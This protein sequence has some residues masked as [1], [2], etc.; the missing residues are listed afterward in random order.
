MMRKKY[1]WLVIYGLVL[2]VSFGYLFKKSQTKNFFGDE[3][4]YIYRGRGVEKLV[5]GELKDPYWESWMAYDYPFFSGAFYGAGL[6]MQGIKPSESLTEEEF[7]KVKYFMMDSIENGKSWWYYYGS[8]NDLP[9]EILEQMEIVLKARKASVIFGVGVIFLFGL[10]GIK[11]KNKLLGLGVMLM[12]LFNINFQ[13]MATT[14]MTE[15]I[16]G[17]FLLIVFYLSF[18]IKNLLKNNSKK[19]YLI[20][21]LMGLFSAVAMGTKLTG[22][23]GIVFTVLALAYLGIRYQVVKV[24]KAIFISVITF[25]GSFMLSNPF[26]YKAPIARTIYLFIYKLEQIKMMQQNKDI[27]Y[28]LF[29]IPERITKLIQ[30]VFLHEHVF[31]HK[32]RIVGLG[33]AIF[34][35]GIIC[36]LRNSKKQS[37]YVFLMIWLM[38][39]LVP[40]IMFIPWNA[41]TFYFPVYLAV[42]LIQ[43]FGLYKIG[44]WVLERR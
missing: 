19:V 23:L 26:V 21:V 12:L 37:N 6:M 13:L 16:L 30:V 35:I 24:A 38:S 14:A 2:L 10:I 25:L 39:I 32:H 11:I 41:P 44:E 31:F 43:G 5:A 34:L 29:T 33:L 36:L 40:I 20:S 15:I 3:F 18:V 8:I 42:I 7:T 9:V 1:K 22:F 27:G 4:Y 17:F 28:G